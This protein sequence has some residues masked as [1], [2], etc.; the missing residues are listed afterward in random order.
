MSQDH[1]P[2][3]VIAG[4]QSRGLM[5]ICDHASNRIP[6]ALQDLGLGAA[7][8]SQHIAWDIGAA[9][10]TRLLA[11]RF[12]APAVLCGTSRLVIDCN[13]DPGDPAAM[14]AVSDG[15]AIPGN[16]KITLWDR[17]ERISRWFEPYHAAIE[18]V[19]SGV[20]A[21]KAET[22]L[23]SIHSM[24]P[25]MKGFSRPWPI[26]LSWRDDDRLVTPML[27]A[28]RRR[29][30]PEVGDNEPYDLDPK[31]DYSVPAHAMRRGLRHLQVEFRQDLV[32]DAAGVAQW[33][34]VFGD[35]LQEVLAI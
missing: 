16:A 15:I 33:A 29:I 23:V 26:A 19:L 21:A 1:P 12:R 20:L 4:E 35:A 9:E 5:L 22:V 7:E 13:R 32:A 2:F 11:A 17:T 10:V 34:G 18:T 31:E 30:G 27:A 14:P 6:V 25:V 8:L 3:H 28:L 24:T